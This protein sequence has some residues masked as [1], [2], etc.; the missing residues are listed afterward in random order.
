MPPS[1]SQ[2]ETRGM[3]RR[4]M[5]S[6]VTLCA[7]EHQGEKDGL[8]TTVSPTGVRISQMLLLITGS[9]PRPAGRQIRA[10]QDAQNPRKNLSSCL[11]WLQ[12]MTASA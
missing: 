3:H 4:M 11:P 5:C 12:T 2:L 9:S 7:L 8:P 1:T 10:D 6:C